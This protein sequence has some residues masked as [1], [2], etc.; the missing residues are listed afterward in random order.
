MPSNCKIKFYLL[1]KCV[2]HIGIIALISEPNT[3]PKE[4]AWIPRNINVKMKSIINNIPAKVI[5]NMDLEIPKYSNDIETFFTW[6]YF[7]H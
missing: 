1:R 4:K 3:P 7:K 5:V 2:I 6:R